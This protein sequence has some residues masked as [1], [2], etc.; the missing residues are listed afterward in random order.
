[1][2]G[3]T[4]LGVSRIVL[5]YR[6][7]P[8]GFDEGGHIAAGMELVDKGTYTVDPMHPP[9]GRGAIGLP[10]YLAGSVSPSCR[11]KIPPDPTTT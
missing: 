2:V 1:M 3:L 5:S 4:L 6:N 10:L 7:R 8:Q 9:L 11:P